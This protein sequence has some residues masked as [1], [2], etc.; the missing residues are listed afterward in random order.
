V[1]IS[2]STPVSMLLVQHDY[3]ASGPVRYA[4]Y[5]MTSRV[6]RERTVYTTGD[7]TCSSCYEYI[8]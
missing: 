3:H 2:L 6:I 1:D 8:T 4:T 5:V 7:T